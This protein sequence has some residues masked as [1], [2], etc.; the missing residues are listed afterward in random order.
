MFGDQNSDKHLVIL[1]TLRKPEE[2]GPDLCLRI[3]S[4]LHNCQ[5]QVL[6][7]VEVKLK[8]VEVLESLLQK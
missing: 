3:P 8:T 6:L 4:R 5:L 1:A 7:E 2:E